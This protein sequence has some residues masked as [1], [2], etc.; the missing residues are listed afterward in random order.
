MLTEGRRRRTSRDYKWPEFCALAKGINQANDADEDEL[1]DLIELDI[2]D[3]FDFS[4]SFPLDQAQNVDGGVDEDGSVENDIKDVKED[5]VNI[6]SALTVDAVSL[7]MPDLNNATALDCGNFVDYDEFNM[8]LNNLLSEKDDQNLEIR[9]GNSNEHVNAGKHQHQQQ[10]HLQQ[11]QQWC[12]VSEVLNMVPLN[13]N[14]GLSFQES[15]PDLSVTGDDR[16]V[17]SSSSQ[18]A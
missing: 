3:R 5:L 4:T 6:S 13:N 11:Q 14:L 15:V 7:L 9:D 17:G 16:S 12:D 1:V 10:L 2:P 18:T 8:C